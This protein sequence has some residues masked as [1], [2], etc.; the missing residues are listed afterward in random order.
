MKVD[1]TCSGVLS[2]FGFRGLLRIEE[3][4]KGDRSKNCQ[5]NSHNDLLTEYLGV[6][7]VFIVGG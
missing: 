6:G 3:T 1:A 5:D 7:S 2:A 4:A